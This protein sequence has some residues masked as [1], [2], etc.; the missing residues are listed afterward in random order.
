MSLLFFVINNPGNQDAYA[1]LRDKVERVMEHLSPSINDPYSSANIREW[2]DCVAYIPS[3]SASQKSGKSFFFNAFGPVT[4]IPER[5]CPPNAAFRFS[6]SNEQTILAANFVASRTIW[7]YKDE[8]RVIVSSSQRAIVTFLGEFQLNQQAL[9]WMLATGNLGPGNSWDKRIQHLKPAQTVILDKKAWSIKDYFRKV[10][11]I[12]DDYPGEERALLELAEVFN[13]SF[14]W[15]RNARP[16]PDTVL[17][18]SGGYDSRAV[19][20]NFLARDYRV[21]TVT[22]GVTSALTENGTDASVAAAVAREL[23]IQNRYFETDFRESSFE[24]LLNQFISLGEGRLDH[25]NSFMDGFHMW[26]QLHND[27]VRR[28]IR[29]D[30]VFG[31]VPANNEQD[32][33]ISLDFHRMEDNANMHPLDYFGLEPQRYPEE[34]LRAEAE[35]LGS[36]RDRLYRSFRLPYVLTGLHDLIQSYVEVID[37]LLHDTF[38]NYMR[39]LPDNFRTGKSLY[40]K[41]AKSVMMDDVP[42][43]IKASIPEPASILRS[44][45]IVSLMLDEMNAQ[46]TRNMFNGKLI[47]W[48]EDNLKVDDSLVNV[49]NNT[50]AAWVKTHT[51]WQLKKL[52]RRDLIRYKAD[53]NQLAFRVVLSSRMTHKLNEDALALQKNGGVKS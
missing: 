8:R 44:A 50:M 20:Y 12:S 13:V 53:F 43:A 35:S 14:E 26:N 11:S 10:E 34:L 32:V 18:L 19:L 40:I 37:P 47:Q 9:S 6:N 16:D 27:G 48:I 24:P 2:D 7:Y 42:I 45:R 25:V 51:P 1:G 15:C 31:W 23:K 28:V 52:L 38:I 39:K 29:A 41:Y 49:T 5:D 4:T 46:P 30:E 22:W 36:W 21:P 3:G 17:T 33:R